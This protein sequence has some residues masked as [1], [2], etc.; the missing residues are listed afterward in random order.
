MVRIHRALA[1]S[2]ELLFDGAPAGA[3]GGRDFEYPARGT[4]R[5]LRVIL[6]CR[7]GIC[8]ILG[9]GVSLREGMDEGLE[10]RVAEN[11]KE[12]E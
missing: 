7:G 10:Q 3:G 4:R 8:R 6:G 2:L 9:L 1:R 5:W 12:Y 11:V